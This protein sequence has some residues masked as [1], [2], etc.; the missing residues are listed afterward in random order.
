MAQHA[1]FCPLLEGH[2][3]ASCY[4]NRALRHGIYD[5][6]I[7][8]SKNMTKFRLPEIPVDPSQT[9]WL[10]QELTDCIQRKIYEPV[11]TKEAQNIHSQGYPISNA[12]IV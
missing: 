11:S 8:T 3:L 9:T 5:P 10:Q 1:D 7:H 12:F 4:E 2:S 6:P